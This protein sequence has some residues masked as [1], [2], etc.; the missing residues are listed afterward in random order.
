MHFTIFFY[1]LLMY[2]KWTVMSTL[3]IRANNT[4]LSLYGHS[5]TFACTPAYICNGYHGYRQTKTIVCGCHCAQLL[6]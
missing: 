4:R 6:S 1:L 5:N 2:V 3:F